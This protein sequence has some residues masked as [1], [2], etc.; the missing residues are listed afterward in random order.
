MFN[1]TDIKNLLSQETINQIREHIIRAE[2]ILIISHKN[3]DG[4]T[5]GSALGVLIALE[6]FGK[7]ASICCCDYPTKNFAYLPRINEY[8]D[9]FNPREY[10]LIFTID[11]GANYL[12]KF[13]ETKPEILSGEYKIINIDHHPSNDYFGTINLVIDNAAATAL[14]IYF[15]LQQLNVIITKK[16]ATCLLTGIYT[17]TGSFMHSNTTSEVYKVAGE[18]IGKGA[19]FRTIAKENFQTLPINQM[20]LWGE[21]LKRTQINDKKIVSSVV[22]VKDFEKYSAVQSDIAGVID[23]MNTLPESKFC[24]LLS[25]PKK[26]V[27]KGSLRTQHNNVDLSK[28]AGV[29][30]GGGHQKAAGFTMQGTLEPKTIWS[31]K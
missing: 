14:I 4:D 11:V 17:D 9:D 6:Q 25:E 29:F 1:K 21:I 19:D 22:T 28:I 10:D 12:L 27:I 13:N 8:I 15:L 16:I 3:P 26:G 23:Y 24:I 31:I 5:I 20:R 18:L 7:K 30:G 2:N